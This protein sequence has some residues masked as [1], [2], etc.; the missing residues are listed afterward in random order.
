MGDRHV[1]DFLRLVIGR[2]LIQIYA[3]DARNELVLVYANLIKELRPKFIVME[4]VKGILTLDKGAY[5]EN[6]MKTLHEAGYNAEYRLINMADLG[7]Q[8]LEIE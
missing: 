1:K 4:N 7:Y 6:V 8:R 2:L 5:L 3:H